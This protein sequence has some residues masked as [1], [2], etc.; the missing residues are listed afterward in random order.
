M[1][2]WDDVDFIVVGA[3]T[4]GCI[5]AARLSESGRHTVALLEAG[6]E[7]SNFWVHVPL[8]VGLLA[9]EPKFQHLRWNY[10]G[11]PEPGLGGRR[12][13]QP[14]GRMLGGT[15]SINGMTWVRGQ[16]EDFDHWRS[17]GN[18]GWGYEDVLPWFIRLEDHEFGASALHGAGGPSRVKVGPKNVLGDALISA[19][20][21]AGFPRNDDYNGATQ[22]GFGYDQVNIRDGRRDSTADAYLRAA[23]SR[24][25]L[26]V[27]TNALASR[28]TTEGGRATGVEFRRNGETNTL[29][30]RA[31]VIVAA[32]S[33]N[34]PQLL[35]CSGIGPGALLQQHGV[36]VVLD[37]PEVGENLQ[38]HVSVGL[39]YRCTQPIT[40]NEILRSPLK[41][42]A[43]GM[44]YLLTRGGEMAHIGC[45]G[46][47][48]VK[49]DP[50]LASP[51]GKIRL[52][53]MS[54]LPGS[55]ATAV[56]DWPGF[57]LSAQLVH[58]EARGHIRIQG[59]DVERAPEIF[60][61]LLGTERDLAASARMVGIARRIASMPALAPYVAEEV[62]PGPT[63]DNS[64]LEA[65]KGY[66]RKAG[67][68]GYHAVGSCRMGTDARAV[69]DPCLRV[70]GIAGL[71]VIDASIMPS[72]TGGNT[73][74][75]TMMIAEKGSALVLEDAARR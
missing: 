8:G 6:G 66:A 25:N 39:V 14:R 57:S 46:T 64:D 41:K 49:S 29:R 61:N 10:E 53:L 65:L 32:G 38:D 30:A 55:G 24:P 18:T 13:P 74:V 11:A 3:G 69:V 16:R 22:E 9:D 28:V 43:M 1:A 42:L 51:D 75:P 60:C 58:P 31:E 52:F 27:I 12:V 4:A 33:F 71:R 15:G 40:L 47:G 34:S 72:V 68:R 37:A 50:A 73:A 20:Q 48:F 5:L 45:Y 35:Q 56:P 59:P 67:S 26:R 17:L 70:R 54:R 19:A 2:A 23:R 63:L 7:D 21:Q 44:Q 62:M 36:R